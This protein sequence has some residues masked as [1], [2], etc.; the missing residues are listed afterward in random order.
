MGYPLSMPNMN[1][2]A[3]QPGT[4]KRGRI[5]GSKNLPITNDMLV[6]LMILHI[7]KKGNIEG[8][9]IS[10][11]KFMPNMQEDI[12][13][14]EYTTRSI[15]KDAQNILVHSTFNVLDLNA[16]KA[17]RSISMIDKNNNVLSTP[18][19]EKYYNIVY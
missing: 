1:A 2:G 17:N 9:T 15:M 12:A 19:R 6:L 5:I 10:N 11:H 4:L 8:N 13:S 18:F 14:L 3:A 16:M 7:T